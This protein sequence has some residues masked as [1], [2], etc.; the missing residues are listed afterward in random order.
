MGSSIQFYFPG[1]SSV[2]LNKHSSLEMTLNVSKSLYTRLP[3][4]H[5]TVQYIA[6]IHPVDLPQSAHA[7]VAVG[8][9]TT[10][11][12]TLNGT[13]EMLPLSKCAPVTDQGPVK[14][15]NDCM[16][17]YHEKGTVLIEFI[18]MWLRETVQLRCIKSDDYILCWFICCCVSLMQASNIFSWNSW[19]YKA[20]EHAVRVSREPLDLRLRWFS[21]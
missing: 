3:A 10:W 1:I 19:V 15:F 16:A 13:Y 7:W 2:V 6:Y 12:V 9:K 11:A 4:F 8:C 17:N 14:T 5:H 20:E 18:L 21:P